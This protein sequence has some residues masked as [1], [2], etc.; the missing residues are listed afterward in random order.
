MQIAVRYLSPQV[1]VCD[2]IC[3]DGEVEAVAAAANSGVAV[4]TS[5]HAA[6]YEEFLRK[7]QARRLLETG[8]FQKLV[9]LEGAESPSKIREI[10]EVP[11]PC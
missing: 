2:E 11:A 10:R 7:P 1:I 9:L 6:D 3:T 5:L 4:V 8:A